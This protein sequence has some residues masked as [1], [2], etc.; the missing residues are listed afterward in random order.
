MLG[1]FTDPYPDELLYSACARYSALMRYPNAAF[2]VQ[3][4]FGRKNAAAV[5]DLPSH[6]DYLISVLPPHHNYTVDRL[7]NNNTLA[8]FYAPFLP[9]KRAQLLRNDMKQAESMSHTHARVGITST[10][11]KTPRYLRFCSLCAQEDR[12]HFG[13]SYWHRVHQIPGIVLCPIHAV[14]LENS[15]ALWQE[16]NNPSKLS[17]ANE[18]I[19][20]LKPRPLDISDIHQGHLLKIARDVAWLLNWHNHTSDIRFLRRRYYNLL[21]KRGFAYYNG[22]IKTSDLS[23][24]VVSFFTQEFLERLQSGIENYS[25]GWVYR[26]VHTNTMK[27]AQ[28]PIRHLLLITFLGYTA[29]DFFTKSDEFKPFG[30]K[31]W[32]CLNRASNHY[33]EPRVSKCHLT[34][35]LIKKKRGR[36]MGI[37]TCKDCGFIY[38]RIGPDTS[39]DDRF[40]FSSIQTH[41]QVWEKKLQELWMDTALPLSEI[42]H[43]LGVSDLTIVRYAIRF[44]LPM[45]TL[46]SRRVS[47]KTIRRYSN[48]RP[49]RHEA[50]KQYRQNWLAVIHANPEASRKELIVISSFLYLWLRKNDSTWIESHLPPPCHKRR[51]FQFVDWQKVDGELSEAVI[52]ATTRIK[53]L[54]GKPVRASLAEI[55]REIGYRS[56]LERRFNKLPLTVKVLNT[57]LESFEAFAIRKIQWAERCYQQEGF[58]PTR[59]QIM[60]RAVIQNNSGRM[61]VVQSAVDAAMERLKK[62]FR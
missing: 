6:L 45:N 1:L 15:N 48:F 36:P 14:F 43:R 40:Q 37:F 23:K 57:H 60:R 20:I 13:E 26:L 16:P 46:N 39:E 44:K 21:L 25:K 3:E 24:E 41:G 58:C 28:H 5:V 42:K 54:K 61:P 9:L 29:E 27:V 19:P 52:T 8:P 30:E 35:S 31:P 47:K 55:I 32:P 34:D 56:Y 33:G 10:G 2:A 50:L 17:S 4:L 38:N 11:I 22:R 53:N 7:I 62:Q 49:T 18:A 59:P 51:G 12:D